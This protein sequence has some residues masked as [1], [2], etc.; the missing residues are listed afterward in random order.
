MLNEL[1]KWHAE[2]E[3]KRPHGQRHGR[4]GMMTRR[5]G[6]G[7]LYVTCRIRRLRSSRRQFRIFPMSGPCVKVKNEN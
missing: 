7:R 4:E 2:E 1:V 3:R 6:A 5:E